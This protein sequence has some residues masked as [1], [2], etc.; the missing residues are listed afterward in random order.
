MT[1]RA[2]KARQLASQAARGTTLPRAAVVFTMAAPAL[3]IVLGFGGHAFTLLL[4]GLAAAVLSRVDN[5]KSLTG[6]G[7]SAEL[8]EAQRIAAEAS[9]TAD[10][11][12][13]LALPLARISLGM[14][15]GGGRWGGQKG[16]RAR[17]QE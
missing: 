14:A 7:F 13:R 2:D 11:L 9:V 4:A 16:I 5:I 3:A 15:I 12:R 1:S 17:T 8:R 6:W 10:E